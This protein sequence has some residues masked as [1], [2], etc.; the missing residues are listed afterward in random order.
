MVSTMNFILGELLETTTDGYR[1]RVIGRNDT[2]RVSLLASYT[3]GSGYGVV[4][5]A[6]RND[7]TAEVRFYDA[8]FVTRAA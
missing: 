2:G 4:I 5:V 7:D 8:D 3:D 6:L 1:G